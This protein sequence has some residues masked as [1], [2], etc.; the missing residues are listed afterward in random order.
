MGHRGS[1]AGGRAGAGGFDYQA[2]VGAYSA[3]HVLAGTGAPPLHQ[4]WHGPLRRIDL[5]T[6]RGADD[7]G[8]APHAGPPV[9]LQCKTTI[10]LSKGEGSEF[11]KTI[12]QFVQHHSHPG[13]ENDVL[14]LATTTAASANVRTHLRRLLD[15]LRTAD[16]A[17]PPQQVAANAK[18][19]AAYTTLAGHI[20]R[21]WTSRHDRLPTQVERRRLLH[22]CHVIELDV[23]PGGTDESA[24]R[25]RMRG[26]VTPPAHGDATW[27]ILIAFCSRLAADGAGADRAA[28]EHQ[29]RGRETRLA[30]AVDI[31]PDVERLESVTTATLGIL[32]SG[33]V[34]IPTPAGEV[35][36]DRPIITELV[37]KTTSESLLVTGDPGI[38][39]TVAL[40]HL[41]RDRVTAG[42]PTLYMSVGDTA[43]ASLGQLRTE[44]GLD[45]ELVDVMA[46]WA[47]GVQK[48]LVVDGLDAAR[49][50]AQ[51]T[52]WRTVID[53]A[54]ALDDWAVVA[55]IRS[56]DLQHSTRLPRSFPAQPLD[57]TLLAEH[58][59]DQVA[60]GWPQLGQLV[61]SAPPELERVLRNPF[62]LRMAAELLCEGATIGQLSQVSD[63]LQLLDQYWTRRVAEGVTGIARTQVLTTF[64]S[65]AVDHRSMTVPANVLT[66]GDTSA[67]THLAALLSRGVL[68]DAAPVAGVPGVGAVR[69]TH[70]VLFDYAVA[71]TLFAASE[72]TLLARLRND[73]DLSL[74]ARPAIAMHMERLW[75]A[76]TGVFWDAAHRLAQTP[77]VPR[78]VTAAGA[79]IAARRATSVDD[80][81]PVVEAASPAPG[82][83]AAQRL[84][85]YV[86][87]AVTIRLDDT[88]DADVSVWAGVAGLL[89]AE[90]AAREL[91]LRILLS[92]LTL[93]HRDR[94]EL[95]DLATCGAA[96]RRHLAHVW[97][98]PPSRL[99]GHAIRMVAAT[100]EAAPAE[101]ASLLRQALQ[102][103]HLADRGPAEL[104]ALTR[105]IPTLAPLTPA[106][107]ED[108]FAAVMVHTEPST[109]ATDFG[110]AV[111][112]MQSNRRQDVDHAKWALVDS[113]GTFLDA[114][115]THAVNAVARILTGS[116]NEM[117]EAAGSVAGRTVVIVSD[118]SRRFDVT[119]LRSDRD[120]TGLLAKLE[121]HLA[122]LEHGPAIQKILD[123]LA[124][125]PTPA[126]IWRSVLTA[127][128][129]NGELATELMPLD[130]LITTCTL[131]DLTG[132]LAALATTAF[133]SRPREERRVVEDA[134]MAMT[135]T[136]EPDTP[137]AYAEAERH[138][139][140]LLALDPAA[141]TRAAVRAA[142]TAISPPPAPD[143][144]PE[145]LPEDHFTPELTASG[146]PS[147]WAM[148]ERLQRFASDHL[149][150]RPADEAVASS[151]TDVE[152]LLEATGAKTLSEPVREAAED[153]LARSVEIWTRRAA[154]L[155]AADV[156]LARTVLLVSSRNARPRPTTDEASDIVVIPPRAT[157]RGS[158]RARTACRD[159]G[160]MPRRREVS[161]ERAG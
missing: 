41:V 80:L 19:R 90:V 54:A 50:G 4:L 143:R 14:V 151:R 141:I 25:E 149:N 116:S 111:L 10:Q 93:D 123:H 62:N 68:S 78:L 148:I 35:D 22:R 52:L 82:S 137:A 101:T 96:A 135:A 138:H 147:A 110:T 100:A 95:D 73:P 7:V 46:R 83:E 76:D 38:G 139:R 124:A 26:L 132:P 156:D 29:L 160:V 37:G 126:G 51:A 70:H 20:D 48:L 84:L 30:T 87:I 103:D 43:A 66:A 112:P 53:Q 150:A 144:V 31:R 39:K 161:T 6:G 11:G 60:A 104:H 153:V 91:P 158:A 115:P 32:E 1:D 24:A 125:W 97:T 12:I 142:R 64:C 67:G 45:R 140:L 36:L 128:C 33:G 117:E 145:R 9:T 88:P 27:D 16:P 5:E 17:S 58:E 89:A 23:N 8:L 119:G 131:P 44:L 114:A 47:P 21:A 18:E 146:D 61:A 57:V 113:F 92:T 129:R 13:Q 157:Q 159:E 75:P 69:M 15:R 155:D 102:P 42:T 56:W 49:T 118:G 121:D 120:V 130:A 74:F 3:T 63:Q 34:A 79:E 107:V 55:S 72:D 106:F 152:G 94:L 108:L 65:H 2:R 133:P 99:A 136:D 28:L 105:T 71:T 134:V 81:V 40:H 86:A 122:K 77:A 85:Q 127:A 109:E 59:L 98:L 154:E